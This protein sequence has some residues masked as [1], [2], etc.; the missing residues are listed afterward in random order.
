M[1]PGGDKVWNLESGAAERRLR[2]PVVCRP[3]VDRY[4]LGLLQVTTRYTPK[5]GG[6]FVRI[7]L[8]R[9]DL[10]VANLENLG[11]WC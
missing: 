2:T 11:Y 1:H 3:I 7:A 6:W 4:S 10:E 8:R 5:L 9:S